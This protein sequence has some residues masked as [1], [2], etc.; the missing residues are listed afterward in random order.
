MSF[1]D[2]DKEK[3]NSVQ[4]VGVNKKLSRK[5][6]LTREFLVELY[7]GRLGKK[8]MRVVFFYFFEEKQL[9]VFVL[10]YEEE[11]STGTGHLGGDTDFFSVA[12]YFL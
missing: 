5:K 7:R 2:G 11:G 6:I 1:C 8:P 12:F 3:D 4:L 9:I 10:T